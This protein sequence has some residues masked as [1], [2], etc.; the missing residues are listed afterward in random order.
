V[1]GHL[2][3]TPSFQY[4]LDQLHSRFLPHR[5]GVIA[6]YI[7]ELSLAD[8]EFFGIALV[9]VDGHVYQAG[10]SRQPFSIQ[11]I[12]KAF[13][14]GMALE[15]SGERQVA[16]K[17][18]VEPS[19]EAFNSIS[20]EPKTGRPR[21]PMINAG[22]IVATSLVNGDDGEEKLQRI[23]TKFAAY[24]GRTL[25]I[26]EA[27]YQSEKVTGHRNR[28]IAHLLRNYEI[29][30]GDPE[31]PL[32]AY[33]RQCSI[34]VSARD[35]ALM[36]ASLANDGVNPITG[37]RALDSRKVPRVLS[38]MATC[39]MYDYSGNWIYQVGMPAKSGVGG[40]IVAVL[41]GQFALAIY[42]P[43]LDPKGNSV[44]GIAVCNAVSNDFGLHMLRVTRM[45]TKSVIRSEY[46]AVEVRSKLSRDPHSARVLDQEG[47]SIL[48]ME[49]T[50]E[51]MFVS[52]E[53]VASTA[54]ESMTG[55]GC[56]ILD[57]SRVTAVDQSASTLLAEL[58]EVL[59]E[60]RKSV[61]ITGTDEH[62]AFCQAVNRYF[63]GRAGSPSF[64]FADVDRALEHAEDLL[65]EKF[66]PGLAEQHSI[67]LKDLPL[68]VGLTGDEFE[69]LQS[70][71]VP[72]NFEKGERICREG[73]PA[74]W[75]YFLLKGRVSVSL[76]LDYRHNRRLGAFAAG[77]MFGESAFFEGHFRMAD[78]VADT[79]VELLA[80]KPGSLRDPHDPAGQSLLARLL[81]NLAELNLNLLAR[82][83]N[84]IRILSR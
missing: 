4:Y 40:G 51:L 26:D 57:L 77:W 54:I 29:L 17:I 43:K 53:I 19:G 75:V 38:V 21:N 13:V 62:F 72:Q 28:A 36:G 37:V 74:D 65:L 59:A 56:L 3:R 81:A 79:S 15:D 61:L 42:S 41:P 58:A 39:G 63:H 25:E 32:D 83:N 2:L 1:A 80:L 12:S 69:F 7:P 55:R 48:V 73:E 35:L 27:I 46:T 45:T 44:R 33:F 9:T 84:E 47:H 14:Y 70:V 68:C 24:T 6:S 50:G 18:D 8:P 66:H 82:A 16:E 67:P 71:L 11:S 34:L 20:L 78:I 31:Q 10:D 52:A 76:K 30:E 23:L 64:N 60:R 22:A 49:L 5:E